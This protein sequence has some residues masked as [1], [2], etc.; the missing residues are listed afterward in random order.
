MV[1]LRLPLS[2]NFGITEP[3][4]AGW[5]FCGAAPHHDVP[6]DAIGPAARLAK[7]GRL[8]DGY[9]KLTVSPPNFFHSL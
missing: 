6:W 2:V 7:P 8:R 3:W 5:R 1:R 4:V 9:L